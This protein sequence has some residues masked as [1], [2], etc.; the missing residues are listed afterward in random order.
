M[1]KL[2]I[3]AIW[4][5]TLLIAVGG[6]GK[7]EL[8]PVRGRVHFPDGSPLT[9]GQV[10][11]NSVKGAHGASSDALG[12]DGSFTLGSFKRDDGVPAGQYTVCVVGA[13]EPLAEGA[14][15]SGPPKYLIAE[16]FMDPAK[17]GLTFEVKPDGDNVLDITVEK[18]PVKR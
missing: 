8:H 4:F 6:C 10:V 12:S 16:R 2:V 13:A 7:K 11:I 18:P 5:G 17:S 1:S 3:R 14:E 9:Q 15:V